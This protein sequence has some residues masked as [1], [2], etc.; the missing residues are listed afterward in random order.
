MLDFTHDGEGGGNRHDGVSELAMGAIKS[1]LKTADKIDICPRC[2]LI[3]TA[4][5][6]MNFLAYRAKNDDPNLD[7]EAFIKDILKQITDID[8]IADEGGL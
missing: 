4:G 2:S 8:R 5:L 1:I 3:A 7:R 6:I